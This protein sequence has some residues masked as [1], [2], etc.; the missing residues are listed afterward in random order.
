[1]AVCPKTEYNSL[2]DPQVSRLMF[3]WSESGVCAKVLTDTVNKVS[4]NAVKT[5]MLCIVLVSENS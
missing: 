2:P 5:L 4:S 3:A 1:M